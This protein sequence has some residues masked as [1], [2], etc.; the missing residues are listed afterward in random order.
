[1]AARVA[2]M[3]RVTD[4]HV[5]SV[6]ITGTTCYLLGREGLG[7]TESELL[8]LV[9]SLRPLEQCTQSVIPAAPQP[10]TCQKLPENFSFILAQHLSYSLQL[11]G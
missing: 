8:H 10:G 5:E 3:P 2:F 6:P 7:E 9:S 11:H 1:M 4:Q